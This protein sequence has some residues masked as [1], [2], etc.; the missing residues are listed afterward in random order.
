MDISSERVEMINARKL[1]LESSKNILPKRNLICS[2]YRCNGGLSGRSF[3]IV[4]TP[5]HYG[6]KKLFDTSS[7]E[8]ATE[9]ALAA[10][11][12]ACVVIKST[13]PV[14][15]TAEFRKKYNYKKYFF[16]CFT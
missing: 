12:K 2:L 9:R 1:P 13:V 16:S 4:A 8:N 10:E 15:Y 3:F 5:T 6:L 11:T 7:V 14:W